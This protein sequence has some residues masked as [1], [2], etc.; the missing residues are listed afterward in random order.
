M[1]LCHIS[2]LCLPIKRRE[3]RV[4]EEMRREG[5]RRGEREER[6]GKRGREDTTER[7]EKGI[8]TREEKIVEKHHHN[9]KR[10]AN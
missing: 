9:T 6:K 7:R 10:E 5:N 3:N 2:L 1:H 8:E 4:S